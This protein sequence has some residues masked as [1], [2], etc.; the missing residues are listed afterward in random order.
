MKQP[1]DTRTA[2]LPELEV[3]AK[4]GRGRPRKPDALT[5]AQRAARY[6]A[7]KAQSKARQLQA[8][9]EAMLYKRRPQIRYRGPNGETWTGRGLMPRWMTCALQQGETLQTLEARAHAAK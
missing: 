3:P 5:P 8:R 9:V 2:E 1:E 7:R 6:R 4:R